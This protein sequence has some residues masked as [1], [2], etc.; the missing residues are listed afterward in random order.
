MLFCISALF[1]QSNRRV[2][3]TVTD[4]SKTI[5]S[6]ANVMLIIG[7]DTLHTT[8]NS[9][10]YFNF[11]K[12]KAAT[13][14][15]DIK[16]L[17]YQ[18][19]SRSYSFGKEKQLELKDINLK[20]SSNTLKEVVIKAKPNPI[21][22]MQDTIE[23]NAAAYQV[24]EGD[25]VADLLKQF[26]GLEID[27]EYNVKTMGKEMVK[28]RVN[29]KDFF[30][31]N[32]KDFISKLPAAIVAKIQVIDDFGDQS[33]FTGIK[34]GEPTKMLNIVTKPGMNKGNFGNMSASAGTNNQLGANA[35]VNF[36]ND[37]KQSGAGINYGTGNNGAGKTTNNG[38]N[39]SY[40]DKLGKNANIGFNYNFDRNLAAFA[41]QQAVET[42]NPLGTFYN[43]TLSNGENKSANHNLNA[44][45]NFNNKKI[46]I[47]GNIGASFSNYDNLNSSFNN[48]SG[49]IRQDIKN[50]TQSNNQSPRI[51]ANINLSKKLKNKRNSFSAS[52]GAST[53]STNANN[54]INTNTIYYDK[55]TQLLQKDST[56]NRNL[57]TEGNNQNFN[58]RVNYSIGLKKP[59]D[60]LATQSINFN[61]SGSVGKSSNNIATF[62]F[63]NLMNQP[64]Y[65]DS[66][67]TK[68]TSTIINQNLSVNYNYSNK[69]MRYNLGFNVRP[70][71]MSSNYINLN[72]KIKNNT[73]NYSPNINLSKTIAK[74]KT[75]SINYSG[76]N[77]N[78][79]IYQLQPIRNTQN[80]QN[81]IVGNPNLKSAFNHTLSSNFNYVHLKS[82]ISAQTGLNFSA[83]QNEIVNNV[84]LI[85]DTLN[86]LKQETRFENT[87]GTYNIGSNYVLN[88]PIKKN[89]YAISYSGTIGL[90]NRAVFINTIKSFNKGL[91][92]SQGINTSVVL[93]KFSFGAGVNYNFSS[94]NNSANLSS[95]NDVALANLGQINGATF[96]KTH[97]LSANLNSSLRLKK[98]SITSNVSYSLTSNN[99]DFTNNSFRQ[100]KNLNLSL[101]A[102]ATIKKTYQIRFNTTKSFNSGYSLANTNPLLLNASLSKMF[103]KNQSLSFNINANDILNQ[104]NNLARYVSGNSIIDSRTNQITRIFTFGLN[105]NLSKFGGKYFRVDA[106]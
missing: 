79:T 22:I 9:D 25:N 67:S 23:Y 38:V 83:T 35:N 95:F 81:I 92:L 51:N 37:T 96:F 47:D 27:D 34:V 94:N 74:G 6:D 88:L 42:L 102:R 104:G 89:K 7:T 103:F 32:V 30:T 62:V 29:G 19:F 78:P 65:V 72:R 91:N 44:N 39:A 36:W 58:Y 84:I 85:P 105:Y 68:Y 69:K 5:V 101:S 75:I 20:F 93:K 77:N 18:T 63:D 28:L 46:F 90:S 4:T 10:G 12:I 64:Y 98:V 14:L 57:I 66:L 26:P 17:G 56:L 40:R 76:N 50:L 61:Y 55:T 41:N 70:N 100:V 86:S 24:L 87:N 13:F 3:G 2:S 59:K 49:I 73:F 1:A 99:A 60:S 80:L 16:V 21:R 31:S 45:F 97:G 82:G 8:S 33:N 43:N 48:Q 11:S 54:T 15:I 53:V 52:L 106:D 71:L